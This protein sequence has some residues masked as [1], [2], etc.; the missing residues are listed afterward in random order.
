MP[1][2]SLC[3]E[4]TPY[5]P[6]HEN[7]VLQLTL[8][9]TLLTPTLP[10]FQL[11]KILLMCRRRCRKMNKGKRFGFTAEAE[12]TSAFSSPSWLCKLRRY[13]HLQEHSLSGGS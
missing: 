7:V 12:G 11:E 8:G 13:F 6:R 9:L 2:S 10:R 3:I 1:I 5:R 4:L